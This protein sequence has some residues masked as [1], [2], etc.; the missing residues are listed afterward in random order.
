MLAK[1]LLILSLAAIGSSF[2]LK[3]GLSNGL[4]KAYYNTAGEEVHELVTADTLNTIRGR[5]SSPSK[6]WSVG[7]VWC[8]CAFPMNAGDTNVANSVMANWAASSPQLGAYAAEYY[9]QNT[10][11]A[12]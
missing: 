1:S 4:Y 10:A 3:G 5:M 9:I 6:R 8:G 7:E 2:T 12:F 11:V